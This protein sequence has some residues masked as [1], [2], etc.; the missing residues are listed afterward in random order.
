MSPPAAGS[1]VLVVDDDKFTLKA[2]SHKL[3]DM[4]FDSVHAVS[5][6]NAAIRLLRASGGAIDLVVMDLRLPGMDGVE[7]LRD[8]ATL[9]YEGG[10][11]LITGESERTLGLAQKLA[12]ARK[13]QVL[14]SAV[15]P[16]SVGTLR[17]MVAQWRLAD[18][19][20]RRQISPVSAELVT[21]GELRTAID[22]GAIEPWFQP[23]IDVVSGAVVGV[24]MLARWSRSGE[25]VPPGSF[26]PLAE[27][28]HLIDEL[29][30]VLFADASD[31]VRQW[32]A[33]GLDLHLAV[34]ISMRSLYDVQFADRLLDMIS[35]KDIAVTVEVTESRLMEDSITPLDNLLRLHLH[36]VS[37]A[38][39]NYGTG[40]ASMSRLRDLPFDEL[41]LHRSF[42]RSMT[43]S[44][45]DMTMVQ[46]TVA[47]AH[48]IGMTVVA[49]GVEKSQDWQLVREL[50]CD[51]A[52]GFMLAAPMPGAQLL[53]WAQ[54]WRREHPRAIWAN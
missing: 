39:D 14:G 10:V 25:Y 21:E 44:E 20:Q 1:Q 6:A 18:A 43:E 9:A 42:L 29:T 33:S 24:E 36:R 23:K 28:S 52:Q 54:Q 11:I 30:W 15:K 50:R 41:K 2:L 48:E 45:R 34:N 17:A 5:D 16:V 4:N 53:P 32:Q 8:M 46:H 38:I 31:W 26:I 35:G 51:F 47:M 3:Q 37:L 40:S 22:S 12:E 13:L 19:G 27:N 7:L 49:E